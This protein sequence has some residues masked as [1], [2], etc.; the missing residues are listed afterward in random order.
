MVPQIRKKHLGQHFLTNPETARHIAGFLLQSAE[1]TIE[2]GPGDG[3]LTEALV[4]RSGRLILIE[5]DNSLLPDLLARF[6]DRVEIRQGDVLELLPG[7]LNEVGSACV[8]SN[9]PYNISSPV[10]FLL[11]QAA[12]RVP[13]M[14]LM[15]QKEVADRIRKETGP[16]HLATS[17]FFETSEKMKLK[18][19]SFSP[20]PKVDSAVLHFARH[21]K[22][23][24][25]PDAMFFRFCRTV[26]ENRRKLLA[27]NLKRFGSDT[28]R[29]LDELGLDPR[30]RVDQLDRTQLILLYKEFCKY[31]IHI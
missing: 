27:R 29:I 20:P 25:E 9:L 8:V 3:I 17:T 30:I 10:T 18:P 2:I 14:V 11:C 24:V 16:L 31:E 26:Y 13:E 21:K 6:G 22:F 23:G 28:V 7:L 5:K 12:H 1:T 4:D 19:G 15:Y